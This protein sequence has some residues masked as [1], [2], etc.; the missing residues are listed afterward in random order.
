MSVIN[1][2]LKK[3]QSA[4]ERQAKVTPKR[5]V[6]A[7]EINQPPRPAF[8]WRKG[9]LFMGILALFIITIGYCYGPMITTRD[10]HF[11]SAFFH[12]FIAN[13][14]AISPKTMV[15]SPPAPIST[16]HPVPL[17][18]NGTVRMGKDRVAVINHE[19]HHVGDQLDGFKIDRIQFN[20]VTL[21]DPKT[22]EQETLSPAASS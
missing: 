8:T 4:L 17:T 6:D 9:H 1:Q 15:V 22:H 13:Q 2:A 18:L 3:T 21:S 10:A 16:P 20:A 7:P 11:Y 5:S 12:R 19:L 14:T